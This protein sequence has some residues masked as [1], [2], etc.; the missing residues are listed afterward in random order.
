M[1]KE[2]LEFAIYMIHACSHRWGQAPSDVYKIM[3]ESDCIS[4]FLVPH[5]EILHT[6]GTGYIVSDI[7]SFLGKDKRTTNSE[8]TS[9]TKDEVME[10]FYQE[11]LEERII[12]CISEKHGIDY[13]TAMRT[14]YNSELSEK[15]HEG[16]YG[17]QYLDYK[18]LV[19][20]L[21]QTEPSLLE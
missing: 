9:L 13:E 10:A 19:E 1:T 12:E 8:G 11:R 21:E 16:K 6:Q 20:I 7:E 17:I 2:E 4:G 14:Y 5:Y 15:L 18:V 3:E